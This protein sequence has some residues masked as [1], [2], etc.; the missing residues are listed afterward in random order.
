VEV[1]RKGEAGEWVMREGAVGECGVFLVSPVFLGG[2]P[3][4]YSNVFGNVD[5]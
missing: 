3:R 4:V 2:Y 5:W 1:L